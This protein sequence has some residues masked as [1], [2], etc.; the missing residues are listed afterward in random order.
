MKEG[1][2]LSLSG[3]WLLITAAALI[4]PVFLPSYAN[5]QNFLQDVI[6]TVTL[7]MYVL[8]FPASFL[9][10]P[11]MF[12]ASVFFGVNPNTIGGMYLNLFLLCALGYAQWFWIVPRIL[13]SESRF[14]TL[15]L[16]GGKSEMQLS[17]ANPIDNTQFCDAEGRTRLERIIY[18]NSEK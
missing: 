6:G 10:M 12:F 3:V 7:T 14:Q 11:I 9:A 5:P 1:F 8:S 17:E 15:N 16:L 13:R 4:L 2:K 18:E